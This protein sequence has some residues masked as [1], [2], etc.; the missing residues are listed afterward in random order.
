MA[1]CERNH[2]SKYDSSVLKPPPQFS[3]GIINSGNFFIFN[4]AKK[5]KL[6]LQR[7]NNHL[8]PSLILLIILYIE[9]TFE[10]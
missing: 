3:S 9:F 1:F 2:L 6:Y 10:I 8:T 4:L 5:S 7:N